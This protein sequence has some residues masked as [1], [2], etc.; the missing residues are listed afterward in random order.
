MSTFDVTVQET[1]D[2]FQSFWGQKLVIHIK[3]EC[4]LISLLQA[5]G[6]LILYIKYATSLT[7]ACAVTM[8]MAYS[9]KCMTALF[10]LC[11]TY[12]MIVA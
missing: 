9:L 11:S 3:I 10:V 1:H 4:N 5:L 7:C 6:C 12:V 8:V 2:P